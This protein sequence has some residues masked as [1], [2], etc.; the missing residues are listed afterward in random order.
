MKIIEIINPLVSSIQSWA[1]T[2]GGRVTLADDPRQAMD[3]MSAATGFTLA[4][5]WQGDR[6]SPMQED[7][8]G[9]TFCEGDIGIA[10]FKQPG[11]KIRGNDLPALLDLVDQVRKHVTSIAITGLLEDFPSYDSMRVLTTESGQMLH[12]YGLIFKVT[13]THDTK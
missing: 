11:L 12:G 6:K 4:I 9:N 2:Y 10:V 7:F 13:Y 8:V 5:F 3:L 1:A